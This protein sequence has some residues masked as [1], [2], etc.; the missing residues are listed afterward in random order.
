MQQG[1]GVTA[2]AVIVRDKA[3]VL[4]EY[5]DEQSGRHFNLPGGGVNEGSYTPTMS[6]RFS[7]RLRCSKPSRSCDLAVPRGI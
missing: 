1:I 6:C 2:R 7:M 3:I 5:V 4:S